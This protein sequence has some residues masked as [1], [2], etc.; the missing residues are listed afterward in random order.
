MK[1]W[2]NDML[3]PLVIA[4]VLAMITC[5]VFANL[6]M[7]L[8]ATTP[9]ADRMFFGIADWKM[10]AGIAAF[11]CA[12]IVYAAL[13]ETVP[14]NVVQSL[15]AGQFIAV[16]LASSYVLGEPIPTVRWVGI[17]FIAVGIFIAGATAR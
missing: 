5:T 6:L 8:G 2:R 3:G 14:L 15:A 7:K 16:I 1:L 12:A 4:G 13:L 11:A 9:A 17:A 10:V